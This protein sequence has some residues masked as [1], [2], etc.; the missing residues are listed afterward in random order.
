MRWWV[1]ESPVQLF[2]LCCLFSC[3]ILGP[4]ACTGWAAVYVNGQRPML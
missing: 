4:R 2:A 3:S 1:E